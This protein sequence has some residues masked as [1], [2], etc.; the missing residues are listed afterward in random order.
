M[1]ED[2]ITGEPEELVPPTNT[3]E[4]VI[5]DEGEGQIPEPVEETPDYAGEIDGLK[6]ALQEERRSREQLE[7]KNRFIEQV[8]QQQQRPPEP[9]APEY[10]PDDF[11]TYG[12][13]DQMVESKLGSVKQH[14]REQQIR[15]QLDIAKS[16][17]DDYDEV[18]D[19]ALQMAKSN[20]DLDKAVMAS[21]NPAEMAYN[22]GRT[23]PD[24]LDKLLNK[25]TK[26]TT[27]TVVS[28][29]NKNAKTPSTLTNTNSGKTAK[30]IV[31][32]LEAPDEEYEKELRRIGTQGI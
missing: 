2:F 1:P 32:W 31:D 28:Q 7:E 5:Q 16:K 26:E 4:P 21:E 3:E 23:H 17:Y 13:V 6:Q 27:E 12:G 24:Y 11:P 15:S 22:L 18:Y 30:D 8:F 10:D 20:P 9:R 25:K 19:L 29:L 14:F